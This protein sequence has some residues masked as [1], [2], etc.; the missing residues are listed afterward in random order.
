VR[1][2]FRSEYVCPILNQSKSGLDVQNG[3]EF[4]VGFL[5]VGWLGLVEM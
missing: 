1:E 2:T 4:V 5:D 3:V